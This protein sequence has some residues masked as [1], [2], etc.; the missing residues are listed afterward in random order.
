MS[1]LQKLSQRAVNAAPSPT[2]GITAK[3]N[4]LKAEGKDIVSFSAGEP[5]FDTPE[6]VKQAAIKALAAGQTKYTPSS[7]T[8]ALKKAIIDKLQRDNGLTYKPNEIIASCGAKHSI[9]NLMQAIINDGDEVIIPAPYWVSYPEQAKLADGVPVIVETG[10]DFLARAEDIARAVTTKTKL[11]VLNSPSNPTGAVYSREQLARIADL[12]VTHG[13]YVMSDEIYEK[14]LFD[15]REF[16]SIASLGPEIKNLTFTVNGLSKSHSMTG[17]RIGYAAGDAEIVAAMGRIQDQSTSNP[18]SITQAAAVE[19]LNGPQEAVATMRDAFEKRR[20]VIVDGLNAIPGVECP[21]PGGAFYVFPK[22][23]A[24]YGKQGIGADGKPVT[25]TGS[26][27]FATWLL[28][29]A[30]VAVVPG[31]GFGADGNVRLSYATSPESIRKG[32]ERIAAAV[33]GL[34]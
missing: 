10:S 7:G 4:A 33:A 12:A 27:A 18:S 14:I 34:R 1:N 29:T 13:F 31:S 19:A 22:V 2:L 16:V 32:L 28:E 20:T 6:N 21:T 24:Y 11:L 9:Y 17:W 5:D 25:I 30:Q 8:P 26:D 3:A 15:D 23:S